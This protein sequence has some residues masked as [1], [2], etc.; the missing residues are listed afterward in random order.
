M[1]SHVYACTCVGMCVGKR[2]RVHV[3]RYGLHT[4]MN[5]YEDTYLHTQLSTHVPINVPMPDVRV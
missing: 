2:G 3:F 5:T 1:P 4:H